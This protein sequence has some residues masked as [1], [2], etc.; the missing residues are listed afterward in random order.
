MMDGHDIPGTVT[1]ETGAFHFYMKVC[2]SMGKLHSELCLRALICTDRPSSASQDWVIE[3]SDPRDA[4]K[5]WQQTA[6]AIMVRASHGAWLTLKARGMNRTRDSITHDEKFDYM[7]ARSRECP[8]AAGHLLWYSWW[9]VLQ[10]LYETESD[11]KHGN[12][13]RYLQL[14][15]VLQRLFSITNAHKYARLASS[16]I[17]KW[18]SASEGELLFFE[19]FG[20]TKT[21]EGGWPCWADRFV[22]LVNKDIRSVCGKQAKRGSADVIALEVYNIASTIKERRNAQGLSARTGNETGLGRDIPLTQRFVEIWTVLGE[23]NVFGALG[24]PVRPVATVEDMPRGQ[25]PKYKDPLPCW[26]V[27]NAE[28]HPADPAWWE[29]LDTAERRVPELNSAYIGGTTKQVHVHSACTS[30]CTH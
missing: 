6:T 11:G 28:G 26:M 9:T 12:F 13:R 10:C 25:G 18:A 3:P 21:T 7:I 16:S 2:E 8:L 19:Q 20:F 22:E 24:T 30:A 1:S 17:S 29:H 15:P 5:L 4:R 14:L 23:M 27:V